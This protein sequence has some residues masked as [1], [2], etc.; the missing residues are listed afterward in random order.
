[1]LAPAFEK[2]EMSQWLGSALDFTEGYGQIAAQ[3]GAMGA[4]TQMFQICCELA[5]V[6]SLHRSK[7][8]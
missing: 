5:T 2:P 6:N 8:K 1:M 4:V 7:S 3:C